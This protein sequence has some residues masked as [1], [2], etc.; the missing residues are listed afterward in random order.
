VSTYVLPELEPHGDVVTVGSTPAERGAQIV[1]DAQQRAVEIEA[2]ARV[3]GEA[4]GYE[5]GLARAAEELAEPRAAFAAAIV[6]L[7]ALRDEISADV[8][9]HSVELA[10]AIAER[11]VGAAIEVDPEVVCEVVQGALRR[12]VERDRLVVDVNPDDVEI[13]RQWIGGQS[14]VASS[15]VEVRAERRVGRGGAVVRTLE[16]EID[17]RIPEQLDRARE[18]LRDALAAGQQ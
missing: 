8:E 15:A 2:E 7:G 11:I 18:V 13:V 1:A 9:R 12:V 6:E 16:G 5:A 4:A 14:E 3:A 10:L 17:A